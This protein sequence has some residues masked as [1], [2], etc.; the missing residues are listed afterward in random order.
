MI[1]LNVIKNVLGRKEPAPA[2]LAPGDGAT[3]RVLNV[4]GGSREIAIPQWYQDWT[5]LLLD[6]DPL[7]GADVVLDARQLGTLP[8]SLFDAVYC[9]HNLEHY[10]QHDVSKVLAGFLHVLKPDGFAE[11]HVPD[12]QQ[13]MRHFV[14]NG[15]DIHGIL[16]QSPA[17]PIS[18]HDVMYGWGKQIAASGVDFYAHKTGFTPN[19]LRQVLLAAGFAEVWLNASNTEFAIGALV[20]KQAPTAAQR[21]LLNLPPSQ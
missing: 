13:V 4:G 6:I 16:Y 12:M 5:H 15:G 8:S 17:G 3:R 1:L 14:E 2:V 18:V 21:L 20:F 19:S 7:T 9:S 11:I 10:Y